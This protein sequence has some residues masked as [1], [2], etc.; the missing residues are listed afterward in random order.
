MFYVFFTGAMACLS[1][2]AVFHCCY[3]HSHALHGFFGKSV[4]CAVLHRALTYPLQAGLCGH[5]S[6]HRGEHLS[7]ALLPLLLPPEPRSHIHLDDHSVR[8]H[9]PGPHMLVC[10]LPMLPVYPLTPCSD[11][12]NKPHEKWVRVVMFIGLSA[13]GFTPWF[14]YVAMYGLEAALHVSDMTW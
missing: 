11:A 3:A 4:S 2:S 1:F 14:H 13:T 5:Y 10:M 12:Y 8:R 9:L 7:R 6:T